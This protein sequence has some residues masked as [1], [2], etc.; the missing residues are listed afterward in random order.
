VVTWLRILCAVDFS[1]CSRAGLE[2]AVELARRFDARL[3]LVHVWRGPLAVAPA[4]GGAPAALAAEDEVE[5]GRELDGW[6]AE[7]E[8]LLGREVRATLAIGAAVAEVVRVAREEQS[9][10]V[11]V[12]TH[13]RT[14]VSRAVL[15]SVAEGVVRQAPCA[16]LVAREV[17][18]ED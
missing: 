2:H 15:G 12:G 11:V 17:P 18:E 5:L 8:R 7:A 3:S 1:T 16:V 6:R 13:G 14:G 4:F 9:D 10:L